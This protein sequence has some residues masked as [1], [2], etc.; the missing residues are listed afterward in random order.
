M[1]IINIR[2]SKKC[3][4]CSNCSNGCPVNAITMIP[5][6]FGFLV[7][8]VDVEKCIN[9]GKCEKVCP[10]NGLKYSD[11]SE[12]PKAKIVQAKDSSILLDVASGG[13][14]TLLME[15][16]IKQLS[17]YVCGAV[18][19]ADFKVRHIVSNDIQSIYEMRHSKYVQSDLNSCII[20]IEQL[21]KLGNYVLFIGTGCQVYAV[22]KYLRREY[23]RFFCIDLV[24]HG[25]PSPKVQ[26]EYVTY[27]ESR[28]KK[29]KHLNNR[30]KKIYKHSYVST[31]LVEYTD[32]TNR[33]HRYS[34]DPMADAF[35]THLSIRDS[36]FNCLFKTIGRISDLTVGDFWFSE[37]YGMG[38]DHLGVNLCLIQSD[39]GS[40]L[41]DFV[42]YALKEVDI[43]S[44]RA[45][46]LNGGMIYSSCKMNKNRDVFFSELGQIPFDDLVFKYDGISKNIKFKNRLREVF[47]PIL[48]RT[49]Y[50]NTRL[51]KSHDLRLK[52]DIPQEKKGKLHY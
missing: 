49:K 31:Y 9:C 1:Y 42:N 12:L 7:P 20:D 27:L 6:N 14:C 48:R 36:C 45:I 26:K 39:K 15:Y 10:V 52:R 19:D 41:L 16:F 25:T 23:D 50:Y 3:V 21:L 43:D 13:L 44:E 29:I 38:E 34:D 18:Y 47:S 2:N 51:K 40:M 46:I 32:G 28:G 11:E 4:G 22:K 24:C 5:D 8:K 33:I 30:N 17:G 37:Q 35:F